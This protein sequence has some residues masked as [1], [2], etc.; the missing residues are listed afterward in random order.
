MEQ[1]LVS[2]IQQQKSQETAMLWKRLESE[3]SWVCCR[4]LVC[5]LFE[6]KTRSGL[7]MSRQGCCCVV[8]S[9]TSPSRSIW[10]QSCLLSCVGLDCLPTTLS[11]CYRSALYWPILYINLYS[12][13]NTVESTEWQIQTKEREKKH[14][15]KKHEAETSDKPTNYEHE[16]A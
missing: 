5:V 3:W 16:E 6:D 14:A 4:S 7:W 9:S 12:P 13:H 8:V 10:T 11:P 15:H 1:I 2:K